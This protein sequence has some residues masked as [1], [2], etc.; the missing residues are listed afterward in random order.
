M[1]DA[2]PAGSPKRMVKLGTAITE[3]VIVSHSP[4]EF[5]SRL[6]DPFW[7]QAFGAVMGM[8]CSSQLDLFFS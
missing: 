2:S 8:D 4:S 6:S 7:F 5:L 1:A 3:H